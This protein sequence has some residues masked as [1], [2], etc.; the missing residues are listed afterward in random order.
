[1]VNQGTADLVAIA[2][3][4]NTLLNGAVRK[5]VLAEPTNLQMPNLLKNIRQAWEQIGSRTDLTGLA[6]KVWTDLG[7]FRELR[8]VR[9]VGRVT[10]PGNAVV[11]ALGSDNGVSWFASGTDYQYLQERNNDSTGTA[12]SGLYQTAANILLYVWDVANGGT[13]G[14]TFDLELGE[15]NQ[16]RFTSFSARSWEKASTGVRWRQDM[17]GAHQQQIAMNALRLLPGGGGGT[18]ASGT[19]VLEGRR[20]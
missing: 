18:F 7:N 14:S 8:I 20:G 1:V 2:N 5:D 9:G 6:S 4:Y 13:D 17:Q 12:P 3:G 15:F 16:A 11:L 19:I 10:A